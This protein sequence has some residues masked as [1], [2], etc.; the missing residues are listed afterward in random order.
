MKIILSK[1][2]ANVLSIF[3]GYFIGTALF[4]LI[5]YLSDLLWGL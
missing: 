4:F 2:E 5:I 1:T 3:I